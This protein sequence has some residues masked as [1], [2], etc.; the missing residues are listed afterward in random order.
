MTI[1]TLTAIAL[2]CQYQGPNALACQKELITCM[3]GNYATLQDCVL[4]R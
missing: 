2:L 4:K 3:K 1:E